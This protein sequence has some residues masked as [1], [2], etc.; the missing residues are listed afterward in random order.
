MRVLFMVWPCFSF[1]SVFFLPVALLISLCF[2][3]LRV[4]KGPKIEKYQDLPLGLK[5]SS[6][7]ENFKRVTHQGPFLFGDKFG[8]S[9]GRSRAPPSFWKVPG[10]PR[11]LPKLP[12][13]FFGDFPGG[14]L[15]VET[16]S[17]PEVPRKF[18][19]LPRKFPRLTRRFPGLP[20]RSAP[21]SGKPDTNS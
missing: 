10:L 16:N 15:T 20:Q 8:E 11:K 19:R 21:F 12:R 13:K 6:A 9:L 5:F 4:P 17:N 3:S 14:S 18:R 1:V 7:N 2:R